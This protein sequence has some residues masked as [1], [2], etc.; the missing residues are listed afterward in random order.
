[1]H[2]DVEAAEDRKRPAGNEFRAVRLGEVGLDDRHRPVAWVRPRGDYDTRVP[3]GQRGRDGFAHA[4]GHAGDQRPAAA[5]V[6]R[7]RRQLARG[8]SHGSRVHGR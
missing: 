4:P 2:E 5:Q 7:S 3:R 6:I 1:V 8:G